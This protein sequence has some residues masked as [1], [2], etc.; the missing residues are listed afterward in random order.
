MKKTLL[1]LMCML[2][3][4]VSLFAKKKAPELELGVSVNLNDKNIEQLCCAAN[5]YGVKHIELVLPRYDK[6][7]INEYMIWINNAKKLIEREGLNLWSIHI[8]FGPD[9]DIS[10]PDPIKREANIQNVLFSFYL[11]QG[12]GGYS[13]AIIHP[14]FEPIDSLKREQHLTALNESLNR[15]AP[16]IEKNYNARLAVENLPRTCLGNSTQEMLSIF[17]NTSNIDICFD[18]NHLL[19]EKSEDFGFAIGERIKTLHISDYDEINERHWLPGKGVINWNGI[20]DALNKSEY[21]GPFLF[22]VTKTPWNDDMDTFIK[23]LT[24]SWNQLKTS[25]EK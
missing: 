17:E 25:Y 13:K 8:P 23:D 21:S 5:K 10:C 20:L 9:F 4:S 3:S 24:Q 2:C 1:F 7:N 16:Y 22:E 15:I 6:S 12:L 18:V 19:G 14:S 11:A